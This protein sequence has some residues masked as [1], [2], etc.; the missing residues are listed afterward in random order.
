MTENYTVDG[1]MSIMDLDPDLWFGKTSP[2]HSAATKEKTSKR[3]SQKSSKSLSRNAPMCLCLKKESGPKPGA[4]TMN[5]GGGQLLGEYTMHSFG[6][7]PKEEN[8]SRLSQILEECAPPKYYLSAKACEGIL[9]RA[10]RRGKELPSELR[11]A[12]ERQAV[13]DP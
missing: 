3:S 1:Q 2:E 12:L 8:A 6:E 13:C 11:E 10:A 9:R 7:S 5:W 4:Y